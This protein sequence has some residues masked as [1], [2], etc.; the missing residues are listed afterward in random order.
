MIRKINKAITKK[1]VKVIEGKL[2]MSKGWN[3]E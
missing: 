2:G 1:E 3:K